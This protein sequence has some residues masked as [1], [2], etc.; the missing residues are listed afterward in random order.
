MTATQATTPGGLRIDEEPMHE[1][2]RQDLVY[3]E[4]MVP[5][6]LDMA[7]DDSL[8]RIPLQVRPRKSSRVEKH[9]LD[10]VRQVMPI[11]VA[12]M[13]ELVPA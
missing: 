10:V 6:P 9:F 11:P 13:I 8:K 12:E 1:F 3:V 4:S 2:Q 7:T 5:I